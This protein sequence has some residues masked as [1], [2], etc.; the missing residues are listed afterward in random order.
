MDRADLADSSPA[1]DFERDPLR[2]GLIGGGGISTKFARAV[3][4]SKLGR[5]TALGVRAAPAEQ[6]EA[7]RDAKLHIG[8]QNLLDDPEVEAVYIGIPH[9]LHAEW[10][11]KAADA[12]KHILCEKP[13]GMNRAEASAIIDAAERAGVLLMEAFMYRVQPQTRKVVEIV[14]S[15][16]IGEVRLVQA[17]YGYRKDYDPKARHFSNELGGGAILDV[18]C[19]PIS[20]ARLVAGAATGK[21]F[22]DPIDLKATATLSSTGTDEEAAALLT[23]AGGVTAIATTSTTLM[24]G[25]SVRIFGTKGRIELASPWLC[26]GVE[27]GSSTIVV[28]SNDSV[29]EEI[30]IEEAGWLYGNEADAF[31]RFIADGKIVSPAM[32]ADD[33]LGNMQTLDR[34]RQAVG[35]EYEIEKAGGRTMPLSGR[36]LT[37]LPNKMPTTVIPHVDKPVSLIGIGAHGPAT[38][39]DGSVLYDAFFE[40]GGTLYDTARSYKQGNADRMLGDWISSRGVRED[41]VVIGKGAHPPNTRP[42]AVA[43]ELTLSLDALQTDYLDIYF[44]HRDDP[45]VPVGEWVDV[46]DAEHRAGRIRA[47]GGSNWS[48]AR[49]QEANGYAAREGKVG[50]AALSNHFSLAEMLHPVWPGTVAV[51]DEAS[52]AWFERNQVPLFAWS[53]QARGFFT[54]RAGR[55]RLED[56]ALVKSWYS[57]T[58]F[59]RRDRAA[60]LAEKYGVQVPHISLAYTLSQKFPL[61]P[62]IGP[63]TLAEL[64]DSL[65]VVDVKITP[66]E[67]TW[68]RTG[69]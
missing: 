23:F 6:A 50:F 55:D 57:D 56:P 66:D 43:S 8:Y 54:K 33:T 61:F 2:W 25:H 35:L 31:A 18:G 62:L 47:F 60:T 15:G 67:A 3:A 26:Q 42:D 58:N 28:I 37:R 52:I 24:Q 53:S 59:A 41:I 4:H 14:V 46:L 10:A 17:A 39:A 45:T 5:V 7:F 34:W 1:R 32:T 21:A 20:F 11:I 68:L 51:S 22:A 29:S 40:A 64:R 69:S 9:P 13:M 38:L 49:F 19:Y 44:L 12:G 16:R 65:G 30:E 36:P 48:L 63:M 27:G